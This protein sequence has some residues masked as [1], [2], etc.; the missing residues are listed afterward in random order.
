MMSRTGLVS[1]TPVG[2]TAATTTPW[3]LSPLHGVLRRR[4]LPRSGLGASYGYQRRSTVERG[5]GL[6]IMVSPVRVRVPP[7][8]FSSDLQ[9]KH[10]PQK[11]P[12]CFHGAL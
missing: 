8:L 5:P 1:T 4:A 2:T 7:L 3:P 10:D 11:E 9:V 12:Q 6:K